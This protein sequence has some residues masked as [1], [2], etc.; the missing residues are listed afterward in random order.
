MK[1]DFVQISPQ[2]LSTHMQHASG[3]NLID[4]RTPAE[5]ADGHAQGALSMPLNELSAQHVATKLGMRAGR[6]ETIYLLCASGLRAQLAARQLRTE[7]IENIAVVEGG[8]QAWAAEQL[9]MRRTS[10]LL[11]LERQ[12]QI[13]VG[14]L[15]LVV[16]AKGTL[17]HPVFYALIGLLGVGLIVAGVSARCGLSALLARMPWNRSPIVDGVPQH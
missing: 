5:F 7:G 17:L 6:A 3:T 8:T 10:R 4:V 2:D 15:L 13:A 1:S 12:T 14:V 16:L 9:P 11:S